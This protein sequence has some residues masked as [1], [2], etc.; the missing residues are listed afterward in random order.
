MAYQLDKLAVKDDTIPLDW[1]VNTMSNTLHSTVTGGLV[2][3]MQLP[4]ADDGASS[5]VV[6][7][8][9]RSADDGAGPN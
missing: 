3:N 1:T 9:Q 4:S 7:M 2:D 8:Q 5:L 6:D